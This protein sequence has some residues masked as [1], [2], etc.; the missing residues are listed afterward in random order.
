MLGFLFAMM[1]LWR[2]RALSAEA[3]VDVLTREVV[4]LKVGEL[5]EQEFQDLCHGLIGSD[6]PVRFAQGCRE[7]NRKLFGDRSEL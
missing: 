5:T 6:G 4:R 1:T 7:Y 3:Q 2:A